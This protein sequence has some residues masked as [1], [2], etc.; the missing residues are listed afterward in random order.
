VAFCLHIE[1]TANDA[2]Q[3]AASRKNHAER[4]KSLEID[5]HMRLN[6]RSRGVAEPNTLTLAMCAILGAVWQDCGENLSVIGNIVECL[7]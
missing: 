6:E 1:G 5:S 7:L 2:L 3:A 4:A